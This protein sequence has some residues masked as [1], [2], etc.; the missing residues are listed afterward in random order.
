M[1][2]LICSFWEEKENLFILVYFGI[3]DVFSTDAA[4]VLL[5]SVHAMNSI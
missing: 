1:F 3:I 4:H 2:F 5:M